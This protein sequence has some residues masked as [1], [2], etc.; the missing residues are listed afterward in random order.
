M[1]LLA[2]AECAKW[3]EQAFGRTAGIMIDSR[4]TKVPDDCG[5]RRVIKC[6]PLTILRWIGRPV[7]QAARMLALAAGGSE[8][9]LLHIGA[10]PATGAIQVRRRSP[11]DAPVADQLR[12]LGISPIDADKEDAVVDQDA[13]AAALAFAIVSIPEMPS[14]PAER[15]PAPNA[16]ALP[17][18]IYASEFIGLASEFGAPLESVWHYF[19]ELSGVRWC[20]LNADLD[21]GDVARIPYRTALT[22]PEFLRALLACNQAGLRYLDFP[23]FVMLGHANGHVIHV[24]HIDE[25]EIVYHDPWPGRS[26][27][28]SGNNSLGVAAR[29]TDDGRLR[30]RVP[31]AE[32]GRVAYASLIQPA[33]WLAICRVSTDVRYA[34]LTTSDLFTFFGLRELR[35]TEADESGF[36]TITLEPG[37]WQAHID[38][39]ISVDGRDVVRDATLVVDRAWLTAA[40]TALLA[41]DLIAGFIGAAVTETDADEAELL[42]DAIRSIPSGTLPDAL[43]AGPPH[44]LSQFRMVATTVAGVS[45]FSR[46]TLACSTLRV[47]NVRQE[48][49]ERVVISVTRPI[50]EVG[51]LFDDRQTGYFM[52]EYREFLFNQTRAELKRLELMPGYAADS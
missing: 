28:A 19:W 45:P 7:G 50:H 52:D 24:E 36:I 23:V 20:L 17:L 31:A 35:R 18:D 4:V 46:A 3:F 40:P 38:I 27:L 14:D 25:H 33:V 1:T 29:P 51:V 37:N 42:R 47:F 39:T 13:L 11:D 22:T 43:A 21:V 12:A 32:F 48:D 41:A 16:A 9:L 49:R 34:D 2:P 30:W 26:L 15:P 6:D 8:V 10:D 5:G 44:L